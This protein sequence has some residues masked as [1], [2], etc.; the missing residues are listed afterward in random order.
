MALCSFPYPG[1]IA[2]FQMH[3]VEHISNETLG[4]RRCVRGKRIT[5]SLPY[6]VLVRLLARL[7]SHG[8]GLFDF[9]LG[10]QL[11]FAFV[12]NL[13]VLFMKIADGMSRG[14]A[15]HGAHHHQLHVHFECGGFIVRSEFHGVLLAFRLRNG[16]GSRSLR[17]FTLSTRTCRNNEKPDHTE[18][19]TRKDTADKAKRASPTSS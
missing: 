4:H 19:K 16:A 11:R 14:V 12:E 1:K 15:D 2:E 17:R 9:E 8:S 18:Q 3:V 6:R 5:G 13:K 7:R 10:D